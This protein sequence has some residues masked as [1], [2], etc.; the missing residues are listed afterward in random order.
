MLQDHITLKDRYKDFIRKVSE[1]EIVYSLKNDKGYA[2]SYSN[3]F[4]HE[5]G[6][7]VQIICFWSDSARAES[8]VDKEW[9]RYEATPA[10]LNE[11][12]EN[13]CLGMNS[14]GL[15]VGIN[16]D[17]NLFGYEAEPLELAL[18]IIEELKKNKK[19]LTLK[20]FDDLEDME[21]QIKAV[22]KD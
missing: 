2:I 18:E 12:L 22:L 1:T 14:D 17:R 11:F 16:F 13:W 19:S 7:P 9:N 20:K 21:S 5:D 6:K 8:C 10:P 4:E 15:L 3:D